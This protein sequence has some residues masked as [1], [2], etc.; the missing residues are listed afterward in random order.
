LAIKIHFVASAKPGAQTALRQL[1][2][3][4]GQNDIETASHIVTVGGDG[5]TLKALDALWP[6]KWTPVFAMRLPESVGALGNP[7]SL[8]NLKERLVAARGIDIWPIQAEVRHL[9]GS[10]S[11]TVGINEIVVSRAHLQ[12][13]KLRVRTARSERWTIAIGDGVLVATP[14][15][16]TGY[17]RSAGGAV[18]PWNSH[19]LTLTGIA[20]RNCWEWC[21]AVVDDQDAIEIEVVDP[22]YRP[23]RLETI[24]AQLTEISRVTISRCKGE[25]SLGILLDST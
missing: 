4:Y 17:N 1:I 13:S 16:S 6:N 5:T 10:I 14:I 22:D 9:D 23:V 15:G 12:V 19:L 2:E 21:N 25:H 7:F 11:K 18:L 24:G 8:S 3:C 20:V